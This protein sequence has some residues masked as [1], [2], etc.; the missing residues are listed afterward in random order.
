[1]RKLFNK[2]KIEEYLRSTM[3]STRRKMSEGAQNLFKIIS[4]AHADNWRRREVKKKH[5]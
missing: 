4:W 2:E 1:M 3:V 5:K